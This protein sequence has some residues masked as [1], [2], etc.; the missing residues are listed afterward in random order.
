MAINIHIILCEYGNTGKSIMCE[1]LEY[2]GLGFETPPLKETEEFMGF[3][4]SFPPEKAYLIDMPQGMKKDKLGGFYSAIETLK[5][6]VT[7]DTRYA[8]KKRRMDRPQVFVFT[9]SFA[10]YVFSLMSRDRWRVTDNPN[11]TGG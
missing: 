7:Y 4:H 10:D 8:G 6:G 1:F 5:D 9:N 3:V 2:Q 11:L